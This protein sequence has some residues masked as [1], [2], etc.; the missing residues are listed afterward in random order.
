MRVNSARAEWHNNDDY[1]H[2][3]TSTQAQ[4]SVVYKL[5]KQSIVLPSVCIADNATGVFYGNNSGSLRAPRRLCGKLELS[6]EQSK[7]LFNVG[8]IYQC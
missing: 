7:H 4:L 8:N 5:N 2:T 1:T 6:L 3:Q